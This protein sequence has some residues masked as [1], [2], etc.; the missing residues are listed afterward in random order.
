M[1]D[2]QKS[3]M[4]R[5]SV[6]GREQETDAREVAATAHGRARGRDGNLR[7]LIP[8][9]L[10]GGAA[11]LIAREEIPAFANW[12]ERAFF[13]E[14]WQIKHTCQQA[15]LTQSTNPDYARILKPGK[16]HDTENGAYVD[17]LVLGEMGQD[18]MERKI[19]YTCYLDAAGIL[20]KINRLGGKAPDT[21]TGESEIHLSPT[22]FQ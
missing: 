16:V 9:V 3:D 17:R 5:Q 19:E 22:S 20:V 13:P 14:R 7:K 10:L 18:G 15:A 6:P 1:H 8:L 12:W 11:V 4:G 2:G 21:D